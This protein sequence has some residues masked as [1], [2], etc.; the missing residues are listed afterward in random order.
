MLKLGKIGT[1]TLQGKVTLNSLTQEEYQQI[2][3]VF[4]ADVFSASG[5]FVI[6]APSGMLIAG[7]TALTE[8]ETGQF[9]A[10]VFP[11]SETP[12]KYLLYNGSTLI[13]SQ[14]DGQGRVYRTYNGVTLYEATGDVTVDQGISSAVTVKVRAQL[15]S[16][17]TYSDYIELTASPLTYPSSVNISG[18]DNVNETGNQVYTKAF[19]TNNFSARVL[20]VV[21]SL[22]TNTACTLA[23]SNENSAT[24]NVATVGRMP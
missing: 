20:S 22:S 8:G 6:E 19:N 3:A 13:S 21:W 9:T 12:V 18:S 17:S 16:E 5:S 23:S 4:G 15:G 1:R 14:T 11:A 24:V 7:P 2:V 10:T